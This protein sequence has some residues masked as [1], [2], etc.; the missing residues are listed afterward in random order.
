MTA[1]FLHRPVVVHSVAVPA[2]GT[3]VER[4]VLTVRDVEDGGPFSISGT[5]ENIGTPDD[6]PVGRRV[7]LHDQRSG[8]VV[9]EVWSD[10]V[11]GAYTFPN[12]RAGTFYVTAFDHTGQYNGEI[13]SDVVLPMPVPTP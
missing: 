5:T 13:Q 8:R 4:P 10:R 11:T 12:L 6:T 9:R 2:P 1:V 7:R 3:V